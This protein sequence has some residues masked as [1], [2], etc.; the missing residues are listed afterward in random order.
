M[1]CD[2]GLAAVE[3]LAKVVFLDP[4]EIEIHLGPLGS[5]LRI[6]KHE[7]QLKGCIVTRPQDHHT[8]QIPG[9]ARALSEDVDGAEGVHDP[10]A[11]LPGCFSDEIA[12]P[13]LLDLGADEFADCERPF[14][15]FLFVGLHAHTSSDV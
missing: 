8:V 7:E 4:Q 15:A 1:F 6:V 14:A 13:L 11:K 12:T 3:P 2:S 9:M 10:F 5:I